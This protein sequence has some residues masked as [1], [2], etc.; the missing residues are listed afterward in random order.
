MGLKARELLHINSLHGNQ[1]H[2]HKGAIDFRLPSSIFH[3]AR[4]MYH[5]WISNINLTLD[6]DLITSYNNAIK[7]TDNSTG[8]AVETTYTIELGRPSIIDVCDELSSKLSKVSITYNT[9]TN[10]VS[11]RNKDD[12]FSTIIHFNINN[13]LATVLGFNNQSYTIEPNQI[14]T[15]ENMVN[16]RSPSLLYIKSNLAKN[17][18]KTD[19]D[20]NDDK[21]LRP[22]DILTSIP[23][24]GGSYEDVI[25]QDPDGIHKVI[26]HDR[27]E[28]HK[29][30][31][32]IHDAYNNEML[33]LKSDWNFTLIIEEHDK[34]HENKLQEYLLTMINQQSE[35]I[36]LLNI[37]SQNQ[38]PLIEV[39]PPEQQ[40]QQQQEQQPQENQDDILDVI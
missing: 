9:Q 18:Y 16:L 33:E 8:F 19:V 39:I 6:N 40:Q 31:F 37:I 27:A 15:A 38:Q 11:I 32:S 21:I 22:T 14:L 13:T 36:S 28:L 3:N 2:L 17:S 5:I 12:A 1:R 34:E 23:V 4:S 24:L 20:I 10:K 7:Q 29:L 35:M 26:I 30:H 25:Y